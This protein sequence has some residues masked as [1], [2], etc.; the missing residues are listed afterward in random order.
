MFK[1]RLS[2]KIPFGAPWLR[3]VGSVQGGDLP[4]QCVEAGG[5]PPVV[6]GGALL[7][8]GERLTTPMSSHLLMSFS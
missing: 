5:R 2:L 4:C 1:H 8:V 6:G 7:P 3:G